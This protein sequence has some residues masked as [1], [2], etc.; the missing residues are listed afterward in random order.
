MFDALARQPDDPLLA[1]IGLYRNDARPGKVDLGVGVYRDETAH[2]PI[3]RAVKAAEKRLLETQ[4]TKAYVGPEGD[5]VFLDHLWTLVGGDTVERSHMAS[6]QTPGGSGALRLAADLIHRVGGRRIWLGLPSWPN[7]AAIFKAAGLETASYEFFDIP[8]QA[9]LFDNVI[10][11]LEGAAAG[12]AVLLHASCHNPTGG[13]LTEAQWLEIAAL[14]AE[15]GLLPLVDLA[16]QGFGRGLNEDVAGL[17]HL[18]G[19]V[20]EALVAVSCSKSFGL[21][22]ERTGAIYALTASASS[23]DTVRSNLAGLARTSYSMPPD[24][25][26]AVVRTILS[27]K[28]LARSWAEELE[29]M[30]LR[31]TGIRRALAEGLRTRWQALGAIA[32]QEGMFSMLPLSE[33]EVLRLR[34]EHGIYMPTSGRINIAGL[35]TAEVAGVVGNFTSL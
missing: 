34:S 24:H 15:R 19:V 31:M 4:D 17:R 21:Y 8:S 13:A 23:A 10:S 2:T 12:D 27:D 5:H 16:Y 28:D 14:V 25:G 26:A 32:A 18:I 1:L 35:K 30:R 6:V 9:V 3:F 7:H 29:A 20:P 33:A 22:R 11:A